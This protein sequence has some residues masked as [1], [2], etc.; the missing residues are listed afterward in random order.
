[1]SSKYTA[2]QLREVERLCIEVGP[3]ETARRLG[4]PRGS[5]WE[6]RRQNSARSEVPPPP[7]IQPVPVP[8]PPAPI[9]APSTPKPRGI[10]RLYTPSQKAQAIELAAKI[11]VRNASKELKISRWSI[12]EWKRLVEL[13][14]AGK[15]P[16]PT[17]G[18]DPKDVETLRDREIL[19]VY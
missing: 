18:P 5:I 7:P 14:A 2:E 4:I 16:S 1:M 8:S 3:V 12:H 15:T 11:G 17:T 10:A 19:A 9:A 13:A 6:L